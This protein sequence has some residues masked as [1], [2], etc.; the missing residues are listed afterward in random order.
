MWGSC[1]RDGVIRI[2][3][4]LIQAPAAAMEYVVAH[5]VTH[6]VERSHGPAF[7]SA[8]GEVMPETVSSAWFRRSSKNISKKANSPQV[9]K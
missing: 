6:L 5:E 9:T 4:R 2:N 8:L 3:W 7:W 1:G